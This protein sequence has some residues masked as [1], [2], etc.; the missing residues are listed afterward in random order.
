MTS[1][2]RIENLSVHTHNQQCL[3]EPISLSLQAGRNLTILGETGSGKSLLAQAIMGALPSSL[4]A[5]GKVFLFE[6]ETSHKHRQHYWGKQIAMLPQEPSRAL[7]PTMTILKQTWESHYYVA[8]QPS[9]I[10]KQSS[11][12]RLQSLSLGS[13]IHHYPHQLSGGMAQR[14]AFAIAT[15]AGATIVIADEP[16]KGLD[17]E[18]KQTIIAMLNQVTQQGGSVLTITHDIEVASQLRGEIMVMKKG[19]LLEY[20]EAS[21]LL[22]HPRSEY[23]QQLIKAAPLHW[24][25]KL[26]IPLKV[27]DT[28]DN[29]SLSANLLTSPSD[30]LKMTSTNA[31][32]LLSVTNLAIH[33]GKKKLFDKLSFDLKQGECLGIYGPSGTGKS[34]LGDALCGLLSPSE[35]SIRWQQPLLPQTILKLYQDPPAAFAAQVSL[36]T[37]LNDVIHRHQLDASRIPRLLQ[38]L[39]LQ[40]EL[41]ARSAYHVSGG[42]LQRIA[43]LRV[44]LFNPKLI[45]ADEVTSRLD[46]ITQ[47]ETITLLLEQ[48]QQNNCS[49][50]LVS[51]DIDLLK[52]SCHQVIN[53]ENYTQKN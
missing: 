9:S 29:S 10:A 37:L 28:P 47:K 22:I 18:N 15:G 17:H 27:K 6:Q 8:K 41:L 49:L 34:S 33:R 35:G 11:L 48:C 39:K 4:I 26:F 43:I 14:A 52:H 51:H 25:E 24:K 30:N 21:Q 20:G 32:P 1:L 42:E 53:L 12:Q 40:P 50:V 5:K 38:Q 13:A 16:T 19:Q 46:P 44:L 36:Q 3:V 45:F 2:I 7:D 23:A 31:Q